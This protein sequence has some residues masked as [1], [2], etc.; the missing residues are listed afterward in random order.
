[1]VFM[2]FKRKAEEILKNY[3]QASTAMPVQ[4]PYGEKRDDASRSQY[5]FLEIPFDI[6]IADCKIG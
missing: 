4:V 2:V 3:F 1:M 6:S 5:I